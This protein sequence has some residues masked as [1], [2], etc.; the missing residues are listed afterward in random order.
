[1]RGALRG[2]R[3][4]AAATL[5]AA[6]A[7]APLPAQGM[8]D[9]DHTWDADQWHHAAAGAALDVVMRGPWIAPAWQTPPA[10]VALVMTVGLAYEALQ[11]YEARQSGRLGQEG[12]GLGVLD[13]AADLAGA[14]AVE[15]LWALAKAVVR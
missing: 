7:T 4:L 14:V 12:Y 9:P 11:V 5:L 6:S 15:A 10:R 1:M 8:L 3:L 2:W 13:L